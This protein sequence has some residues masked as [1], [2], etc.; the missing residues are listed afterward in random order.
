MAPLRP[1]LHLRDGLFPDRLP[2]CAGRDANVDPESDRGV[3]VDLLHHRFCRSR[4]DEEQSAAESESLVHGSQSVLDNNQW[5]TPGSV[6]RTTV[7]NG[8][9]E[10]DLF[11]NL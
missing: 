8:V 5:N 9:E 2:I 3:T 1:T 10:W 7:A 11:C 6:H 4:G